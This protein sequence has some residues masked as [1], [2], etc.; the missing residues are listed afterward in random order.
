MRE[1]ASLQE[2]KTAYRKRAHR[3]HPDKHGEHTGNGEEMKELNHSYELLMDYCSRYRYTFEQ[4]DVARAYPE[5]D[6]Y[7]KYACGWFSDT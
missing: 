2:I 6:Y 1:A 7:R 5:E 4:E 3:Y